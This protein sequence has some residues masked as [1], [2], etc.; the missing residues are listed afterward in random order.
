M[1]ATEKISVT[2]GRQE[3]RR[4]KQLASR[5]GLSLSTFISDAVRQRIRARERQEAGRKVISTFAPEE[6]PSADEMRALLSRWG[7]GRPTTV[8]AGTPRWTAALR[9]HGADL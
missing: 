8:R 2:I 6:R 5:L 7:M 3:L 1:P 9:N 4:A